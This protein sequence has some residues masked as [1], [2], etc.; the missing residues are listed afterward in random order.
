MGQGTYDVRPTSTL[1]MKIV[2][3]LITTHFSLQ[4]E[5]GNS[6]PIMPYWKMNKSY[7]DQVEGQ[8]ATI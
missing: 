7:F 2:V 5:L 4:I 1:F 3:D 6:M 8:V